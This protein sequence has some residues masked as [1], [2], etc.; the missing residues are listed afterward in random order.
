[1]K[2][3]NMHGIDNAGA[4]TTDKLSLCSQLGFNIL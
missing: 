2:L 4:V 1:M 3:I